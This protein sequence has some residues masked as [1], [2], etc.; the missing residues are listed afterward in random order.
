MIPALVGLS[1]A[2]TA[3]CLV[4]MYLDQP[5]N[6]ERRTIAMPEFDREGPLALAGA[7]CCLAA[8]AHSKDS[9]EQEQIAATFYNLSITGFEGVRVN[10]AIERYC[11]DLIKSS[12]GAKK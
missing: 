8:G 4:G 7:L 11:L 12:K 9:S 1:V 2:M 5:K 6:Y 10:A 3:F